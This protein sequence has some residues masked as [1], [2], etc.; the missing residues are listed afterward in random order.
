V[1]L[2][3]TT[4][5]TVWQFDFCKITHYRYILGDPIWYGH[6]TAFCTYSGSDANTNYVGTIDEKN[7][8][9]GIGAMDPIL[10]AV[11]FPA[12]AATPAAVTRRSN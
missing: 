4:Q 9:C 3:A 1:R 11:S 7:S 12:M 5:P 2:R 10:P 8:E 6:K